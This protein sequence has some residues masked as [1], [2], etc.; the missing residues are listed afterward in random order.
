VL[1]QRA[2]YSQK[3][4]IFNQKVKYFLRLLKKLPII[5]F[6]RI[7]R[8]CGGDFNDFALHYFTGKNH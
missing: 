1:I 8:L 2:F 6:Y 5:L 7:D 3:N 4:G